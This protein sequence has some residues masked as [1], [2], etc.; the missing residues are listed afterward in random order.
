MK[1]H[2]RSFLKTSCVVYRE[3]VVDV[4]G[5]GLSYAGIWQVHFIKNQRLMGKKQTMYIQTVA[6]YFLQVIFPDTLKLT[7]A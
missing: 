5:A 3:A 7:H 4:L 1:L 6:F 2:F